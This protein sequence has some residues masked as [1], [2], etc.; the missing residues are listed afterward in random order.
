MSYKFNRDCW[1]ESFEEKLLCAKASQAMTVEDK[2]TGTGCFGHEAFRP[3]EIEEKI[4]SAEHLFAKWIDALRKNDRIYPLINRLEANLENSR[5]SMHDLGI[6]R[7]CTRCDENAPEGSC[8]SRG[9][10]AKY[11]P[12]LLLMNLMLG[13]SLPER[14]HREDS[15]YFLGPKGCMLKVRHMLCVDYLCPELE[16]ALGIKSMIEIQT[17]SGEEILSA[18]LLRE[19]IK[20]TM[21]TVVP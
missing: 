15:C 3:P 9:L 18:F 17:V 6:V 2:I 4:A 16:K 14:R 11:G 12:I 21:R 8:C 1:V 13:A 7:A 19:A 20:Q 10:E 5:H